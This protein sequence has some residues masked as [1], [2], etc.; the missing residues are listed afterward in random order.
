MIPKPSNS[1]K[2]NL[3]IGKE[4]YR[5]YL[6]FVLQKIKNRLLISSFLFLIFSCQ[7]KV[8]LEKYQ[9]LESLRI[10]QLGFFP[11]Q[12][13]I[14]IWVSEEEEKEFWIVDS[15]NKE[16]ILKGKTSHNPSSTFSGKKVQIIDFSS[17][18]KAGK[19]EII[20]PL[21]GKSYPLDRKS[22]V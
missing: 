15:E 11:N 16:M 20:I 21:I 4:K 12:K 1:S 6:M 18:N 7:T 2:M 10:N 14:A 8:E 19:Y 3:S 9:V 22:V 17:L 5:M 13:K